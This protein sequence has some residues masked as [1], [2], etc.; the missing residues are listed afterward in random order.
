M[1]LKT[2]FKKTISVKYIQL[3]EETAS[4][5]AERDNDTLYI[6]FQGSNGETDWRNNLDFPAKPYRDMENKWFAHR[7]FLRVWK[8]I[9]PYLCGFICNPDIKHIVISGYSHGG[10]LA[11]LCHEYCKF[12][13]PDAIVEG[14][15]FGA[16]RV[17]WG[18]LNKIVR[19][20]FE[21]F[22]VIR[23]GRDIV[24]YLPP[25]LFGFHHVSDMIKIGVNKGYDPVKSHYAKNI[26]TELE[27]YENDN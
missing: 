5:F 22:T 21:G 2:L 8:V 15:G 13:R 4:Y 7:G 26:L 23:N 14:Y 20:R 27:E 12:H 9:E 18:F 16:P 24:T 19:H 6:Y 11:L 3:E 1:D 17:V 10:A 25:V